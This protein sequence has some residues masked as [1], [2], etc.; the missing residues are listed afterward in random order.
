MGS[1]KARSHWDDLL[2]KEAED[3]GPECFDI[4]MQ[5]DVATQTVEPETCSSPTNP[6]VQLMLIEAQNM[7]IQLL[8]EKI[9]WLS[10][11]PFCSTISP[12]AETLFPAS[13]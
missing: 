7:T 8:C 5:S 11:T 6:D 12:Q 9:A 3:L 2:E 10:A 4:S 13:K 1:S